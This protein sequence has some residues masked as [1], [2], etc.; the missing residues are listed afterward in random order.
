MTTTISKA[1]SAGATIITE[2]ESQQVERVNATGPGAK[3]L[4]V[5]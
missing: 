4:R 1:K 3:A 5:T 2:H